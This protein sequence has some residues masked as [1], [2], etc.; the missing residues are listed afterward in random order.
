V[1]PR[2]PLLDIRDLVVEYQPGRKTVT[3]AV[4]G[5]SMQV[6]PG[7]TVGLV[8]E[9]GSGKSTLGNAVLGLVP[10]RQGTIVFDGTDITHARYRERRALSEHL[11]VVLQDPYS[12]LNPVRTIGQTLEE[13]LNVH[14]TLRRIDR[15][16][17][18][19]TML[20]RV[21][22]PAEAAGWYPA[23]FSGGQRQ[24]I[25]IARALILSPRLVIC[26]EPVSGLDLS[27]QAQILNLL[28]ALQREFRLSYLFISHDLAV[29]R[30]VSHRIAV[31]YRGHVVEA[32]PAA[33][34][35]QAPGHPYTQAL[36]AASPTPDPDD[37]EKRRA[38]RHA[39]VRGNQSVPLESA[40]CPFVSRCPYA[41]AVC[42]AQRPRLISGPRQVS[43]ACHRYPEVAHHA[44]AAYSPVLYPGETWTA[45]LSP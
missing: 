13:P 31:L 23:Q 28:L 6:Q 21:G 45:E 14:R 37:Q 25:A 7:E 29:V 16:E 8:G 33:Q 10:I 11:Q 39:R 9:S 1:N 22:L 24:R 40:G 5:V 34:V 38:E 15:D 41:T 20:Q 32:G 35:Y 26:D 12:S 44:L 19:R 18:V 36:L 43:V 4:S 42:R 17:L 2:R 3:R 30:H 27:V